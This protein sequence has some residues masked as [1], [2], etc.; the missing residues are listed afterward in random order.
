MKKYLKEFIALLLAVVILAAS[1]SW[2]TTILTPK[3]HDFGSVWG[4]FLEEDEN[5]IDVM[6]F[7]SSIVYCDVVPAVFW[8]NSGL[9]AFVH[10]GPEQTLPITLYY[11][12]ESLKTQSPDAIFVECTGLGFHE[13]QGYTKTNIGQMPWGINRLQATMKAAE[14]ELRKGLLFPMIFYHDRWTDLTA[15]DYAP[16]EPDLLAG[17]TWLEEY[18][19]NGPEDCETLSISA[20]D[21]Q[22]N[23]DAL[24]E[25]YALCRK[26]GISLVLYRAPVERISNAD[27]NRVVEEFQ[28]LEGVMMLD[29]LAYA[30]TIG[31]QTPVEYYDTLH[32]NGSGAQKFSAFLGKWTLENLAIKPESAKDTALWDKRLAYFESL[33]ET[34]MRPLEQ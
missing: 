3:Q 8:K 28:P 30:Q 17:Y 21:W 32:Y 15:D 13:Y 33:L 7:G 2:L 25:I 34:P 29:C 22:R 31:A 18:T 6:F 4:H 9:T 23:V 16:Y 14:P 24:H 27:W 26:E 12:K 20:E 10:A 5:S 1:L 11:I 19:G